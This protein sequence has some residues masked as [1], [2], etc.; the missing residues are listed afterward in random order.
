MEEID[1]GFV[2]SGLGWLILG[3]ILGIYMGI[4]N[5]N[6][7]VTVHVAMLLGGFVVL[8]FYGVLYRLW[9]AMNVG[10]VPRVQFWLAVLG[11]IALVIGATIL[12]NNGGVALAAIG[13]FSAIAAAILMGWLFVTRA[14]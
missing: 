2:V 7:Y 4:T 10:L 8:T 1:R 11:A 9:P 5:D 6:Q 3:M 13:S 14:H 12:V